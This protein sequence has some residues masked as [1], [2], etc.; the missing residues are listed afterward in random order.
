MHRVLLWHASVYGRNFLQVGADGRGDGKV[1]YFRIGPNGKKHL[2]PSVR[3]E[4]L[5]DGVE[6]REYFHLLKEFT[7]REKKNS[8]SRLRERA[9]ALTVVPDSLVRTQYDMSGDVQQLL[10]R[11]T[12]MA[13]VIEAI[14]STD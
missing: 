1:F 10:S 6:D 7:A 9:T 3:A 11:R 4:M 14:Q 5:R 2:I 13:D 8:R 12:Q